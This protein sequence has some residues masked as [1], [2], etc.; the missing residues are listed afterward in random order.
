[1]INNQTLPT[2]ISLEKNNNL[3]L[4]SDSQTAAYGNTNLPFQQLSRASDALNRVHLLLDGPA[5][6]YVTSPEGTHTGFDPKSNQQVNEI[7]DV[8][9]YHKLKPQVAIDN[10][11]NWQ[12]AT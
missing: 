6:L 10:G 2:L 7:K 11:F 8:Y 5:E 1:M 12:L 4:I 3:W 9:L